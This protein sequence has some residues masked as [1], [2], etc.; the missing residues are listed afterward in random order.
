MEQLLMETNIKEYKLFAKGKVRDV[1]DLED[2]LLIVA[3]DRISA[4]DVV[5]PTGIPSKGKILTQMSLFWFDFVKDIIGNHLITSE[6]KE[7]PKDLQ[8]YKDVL[9]DRSML[10]KKAE[11]IDVECVVREYISGSLWREY[12]EIIWGTDKGKDVVVNGIPLPYGLEESEKLP[13]PIFTPA[14]KAETGHD[15]NIS[16]KRVE[17]ILGKELANFLKEKSIAIYKKCADYAENKGIIISDTKFEFGILNDKIILIDEMLSPDSSRF[18][19]KENYQPGSPQESFDKQYVRDFLE[20][21]NW[22]KNPP[23]PKLPEEVVKNTLNKYQQAY[24]VLIS[25]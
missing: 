5:L 19:S 10:V 13:Y 23:A 25:K 3:T 11:R 4:F 9:K 8:K 14:T 22:D 20:S 7:F 6:V 18:W 21:I 16:F 1:Y 12:K 2:K 17:E 24:Q 15:E